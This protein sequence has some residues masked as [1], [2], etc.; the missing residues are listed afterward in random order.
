MRYVHSDGILTK[1]YRH[2][3][4]SVDIR[5][6]QA[7]K[8]AR[9]RNLTTPHARR[10]SENVES[11]SPNPPSSSEARQQW[12]RIGLIA[13]R[14]LSDDSD[15]AT[16]SS[17]SSISPQSSLRK[18]DVSPTTFPHE[19]CSTR[20]KG[21]SSEH[22]SRDVRRAANAKMMDLQYFLEMVDIKH[23][24][25]ANLRVYHAEWRKSPTREN[26]FYWLDYGE[27]KDSDLQIC[28]RAQLE[29]EQV[30]YLSREE[31][32]D[33]LVSV[34]WEGRLCWRRNGVRID[35]SEEW[36][37]SLKG[38]VPKGDTTTPSFKASD[39]VEKT[40]TRE[41]ADIRAC[42]SSTLN[43][44]P[45]DEGVK[46]K[47]DF[48][49]GDRSKKQRSIHVSPAAIL[50]HLLRKSVRKNTWIFVSSSNSISPWR[51]NRFGC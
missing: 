1:E 3:F 48:H 26:F 8:E 49:K 28:S 51:F 27:G 22:Y 32:M 50:D 33:Y 24:Y 41:E 15:D 47:P 46:E 2:G 4:C 45:E 18:P 35:T 29:R 9:Y 20:D 40:D 16:T 23:R 12:R 37:D 39:P 25:G 11:T 31:R 17:T 10:G 42:N 43:T 19:I 38:I 13:R 5:P 36:R 7:I 21:H 14:A 34:D 6:S 44:E 30:R